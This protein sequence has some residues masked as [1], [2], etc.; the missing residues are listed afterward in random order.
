MAAPHRR[1]KVFRTLHLYLGVFT[2]PALLFFA[3]TGALQSVDL[4]EAA[5]GSD[6]KPP[7]WLASMAHMHKKQSFEAPAKRAPKTSSAPATSDA[8][9]QIDAKPS[10]P[11]RKLW[12]MKAFFVLVALSLLLS[13]LTGVYMGWRCTRHRRRYGAI[14]AAG[15]IVPA[16]LMLF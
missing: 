4:H 8:P 12:P 13:T 3:F 1:L 9:T 7:A 2:A 15:I 16:L 6:Y 11:N 10:A 14:L 5:R